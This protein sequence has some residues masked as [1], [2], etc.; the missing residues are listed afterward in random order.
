MNPSPLKPGV[1]RAN[2]SWLVGLPERRREP[3][4]MD[5][6]DLD[7]G[8]H[9]GAL[10]GLERINRWSGSARLL[11][12]SIRQCALAAPGSRLRILD[13]ATGAGDVPI[14][15][16]RKSRRAGLPLQVEGCDR[17]PR[18]VAHAT[19]RAAQ[20]GAEVR[21]FDWDALSGPLP[22]RY[23]VVVCSLFLHHLAE[24]DALRLLRHMAAT[25]RRLLLV[26]D[27][28]RSRGGMVFAYL[29]TRLL[30]ASPVVHVDGPRSV[31][32]AFTCAEARELAQRAGL[33][34]TLVRQRWPYRLLLRWCRT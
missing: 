13:I 3:E 32:A 25:A 2:G 29:G 4:I 22:E 33:E 21:F 5:Q 16:W 1:L 11:W 26:S 17:S 19:R 15:L 10:C 31:A 24:E 7:A 34:G 28:R 30:S 27:L 12:P 8:L 23:D 20:A 6:P 14:R 18:A 9:E